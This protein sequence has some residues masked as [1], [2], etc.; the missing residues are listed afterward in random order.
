MHDARERERDWRW[1]GNDGEELAHLRTGWGCRRRGQV[2][3]RCAWL[4]KAS[5]AP[6][7]QTRRPAFKCRCGWGSGRASQRLSCISSR[8]A[9]SAGKGSQGSKW[10]GIHLPREPIAIASTRLQAWLAVRC[11]RPATVPGQCHCQ[12]QQR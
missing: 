6:A 9:R 2:I 7:G 8:R 12:C 4:A 11:Q 3:D 5:A 10:Q 1:K